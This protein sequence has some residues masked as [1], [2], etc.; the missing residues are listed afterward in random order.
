MQPIVSVCIPTFNGAKYFRECLDSVLAQTFTDFEILVVDDRSSDETFNIAQQYAAR[1]R[2]LRLLQNERNLGLVGNW[3]RC[4]ELA[5]GEWIKFV[6]Q[7]DLIAPLCLERML[8]ASKTESA[9]IFCQRNFTFETGTSEATRQYYLTY[10]SSPQTVFSN[11]TEI[12]ASDY[13]KATLNHMGINIV[14]E[15]T[16][17]LLHRSVFYRFG[18]FNP[19]LIAACD[20]EFWTRVAVHTGIIFVPETLAT[21]RVHSASSSA[22]SFA[23]RMYRLTKLDLLVMLHDFA[24]NPL[25]TPLRNAAAC[26]QPPINLASLVA[27]RAKIAWIIANKA[28]KDSKSSNPSLLTEWKNVEYFYPI[29]SSLSKCN[30]LERTTG[31]FLIQLK[32]HVEALLELRKRQS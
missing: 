24:F 8:A 15:P 29:L 11:L 18:T 21:F 3:N 5:Q 16:A 25:Y 4:I 20:R 26:H 7:D 13:C 6:F 10:V 30:F 22:K 23:N 32:R 17:V 27:R 9:I 28:A 1:D 2:R 19:Q 14:G 31:Y 12:S